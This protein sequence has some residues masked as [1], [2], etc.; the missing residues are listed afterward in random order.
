MITAHAEALLGLLNAE[1]TTYGWL[2]EQKWRAWK[3]MR[4][5]C[6]LRA[7]AKNSQVGIQE[8][9]SHKNLRKTHKETGYWNSGGFK[10]CQ[11]ML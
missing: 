6:I 11:K 10:K 4:H 2:M 1:N 3:L 7:G 9:T 8:V 5:R